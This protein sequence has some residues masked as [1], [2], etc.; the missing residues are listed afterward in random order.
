L[1]PARLR[2]YGRV[3]RAG[4]VLAYP[5]EAVYGLGCDPLSSAAVA[6]ILI[7]K[8]RPLRKGVILVA[9]EFDQLRDYLA[10]VDPGRLRTA[11]EVWP[12][13]VTWL[14]PATSTTP[15]WLTGGTGRIAVRVSAH[16]TVRALCR[17]FGGAIV[18]TS[19]NRSGRPATRTSHAARA[20]F[21]REL[22]GVVP[23]PLGGAAAPSEIRDLQ[24]G[25]VL[26]GG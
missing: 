12:G 4:G 15:Y 3:L 19:A 25:R 8:Q 11:T 1:P 14:W 9:G 20:C 13:P 7:L 18:S 5:T 24:T 6:R 23:G 22:D 26:R 10:P 2:F 17:A 21:G 16:E